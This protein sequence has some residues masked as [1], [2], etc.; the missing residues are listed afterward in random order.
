MKAI[1][2]SLGLTQRGEI[3]GDK[4]GMSE[5]CTCCNKLRR[6]RPIWISSSGPREGKKCLNWNLLLSSLWEDHLL[7]RPSMNLP[8]EALIWF[9]PLYLHNGALQSRNSECVLGSVTQRS[10]W[11]ADAAPTTWNLNFSE[12]G[13]KV[14]RCSLSAPRIISISNWL[15]CSE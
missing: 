4:E 10:Q 6:W 8:W 12:F 2:N 13:V 7:T 11:E 15:R 14:Q 1:S 3:H 5:C 9:S